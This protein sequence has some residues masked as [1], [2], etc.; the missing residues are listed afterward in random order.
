MAR[1]VVRRLL[2]ALF[3]FLAATIVTY[4]IF[5]VIPGD[6]GLIKAGSGATATPQL[7]ARIRRELHLDLPIYQ[8]YWLFVWNMVRHA[9][10]GYSFRDAASVRWIVAKDAPVTASLV[11]GG[12]VLWLLVSIPLGVISALRPRSLVDRAG[13]VFVLVGVSAPAFWIGLVLAYVVGFELGWTPVAGYCSFFPSHQAGTCSGPGP[14]AYHL[15]LPWLT[16]MFLFAALYTR[17]VRASVLAILSEDYVRTAQAKGASTRRLLVYHVLRNSLLPVVTILG[18]DL[19]LA[20]GSA[21]FVESVFNLPGLGQELVNGA[22]ND[23]QPVVVGIVV[24]VTLAVIVCN[25]LVDLAYA[26]LD[27]RIELEA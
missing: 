1:F 4:L 21:I 8:Q 2:W 24:C 5:F 26:W 10:L 19:G 7:I 17:L 13:M 18:M 9:S 14:W 15:I 20:V 16:F 6:P 3:L 11:L 25:F 27:P 23:D 22:L 12:A